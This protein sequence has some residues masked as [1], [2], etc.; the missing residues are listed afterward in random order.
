MET[1]RLGDQTSQRQQG[2]LHFGPNWWY[3]LVLGRLPSLNQYNLGIKIRQTSKS[4]GW[5]LEEELTIA[6]SNYWRVDRGPEI[7]DLLGEYFLGSRH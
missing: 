3:V 4:W 7:V 6:Q 1:N 5:S 2:Y